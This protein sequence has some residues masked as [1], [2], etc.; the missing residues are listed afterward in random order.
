MPSSEDVLHCRDRN[1]ARACLDQ[2]L[3]LCLPFP[4]AW[5]M[6][7]RPCITSLQAPL[8]SRTVGF[9]EPGSDLGFSAHGLPRSD[10][11]EM[12]THLHPDRNEF[13]DRPRSRLRYG[14]PRLSVRDRP[15]PAKCPE[16]LCL[17]EVL[18]R[19]AEC[20]APHQQE[21][22]RLHRSYGLMRQ[23]KSL[24]PPRC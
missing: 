10:E 17:G 13:T 14:L 19:P 5:Q 21:L 20:P 12:L 11:A 3:P 8:R 4:A 16:P 23:S 2:W 15:G 22:P 7:I 18:P 1:A 24:P 9:P 6:A